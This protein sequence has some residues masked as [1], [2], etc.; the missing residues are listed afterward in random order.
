MNNYDGYKD[1]ARLPFLLEVGTLF[2]MKPMLAKD[3]VQKRLNAE[4]NS[5][6]FT[7]F[8]YQILQ[9]YDFYHLH[10]T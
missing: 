6:T 8:T 2:R 10:K 1:Y 3:S 5:M 7:E 9:G 4:T